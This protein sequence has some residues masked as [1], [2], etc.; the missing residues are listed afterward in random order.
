M[1]EMHIR[2][3]LIALVRATM[4]KN[5][6]EIKIQ[7]MLSS[8]IITRN[9]V[10]QGASLACLLFNIALE[11]VV[12]DACINTRGTIFYKSVQILVFADDIDI[13]GRTQKCMKD[14]FLN[15]ERA[16]KKTNLQINQNKT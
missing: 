4:R 7:N 14:A 1:E 10:R 9:K 3:N 5:Q 11:K 6:C 12:R 15:L 2:Q 16:A 13:I 8:P